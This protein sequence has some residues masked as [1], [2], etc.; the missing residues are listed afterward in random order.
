MQ[1]NRNKKMVVKSFRQRRVEDAPRGSR[2]IELMMI[3]SHYRLYDRGSRIFPLASVSRQALKP[4]QPPIQ[5]VPT[6]SLVD[7][8]GV[9]LTSQYCGHHCVCGEPW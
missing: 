6:D 4:T 3:F 7:Y 5:W 2:D 8:D 1:E 9:R